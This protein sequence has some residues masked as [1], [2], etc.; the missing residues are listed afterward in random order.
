MKRRDVLKIGAGALS[1]PTASLAQ[2][3]SNARSLLLPPQEGNPLWPLAQAVLP[4][5]IGDDGQSEALGAFVAWLR[6]HREGQYLEHGYGKTR[7]A[8]TQ[9]APLEKYFRELQEL[10]TA[11]ID[12]HG[13]TFAALDNPSRRALVA[14]ALE[15]AKVTNLGSRPSGS[16]IATDL[17]THYFGSVE[18]Q[19]LAYE[20]RIGRDTCRDL[21]TSGQRP[22]R[23]TAG[24]TRR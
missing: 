11:A 2:S 17:M 19:D 8:T 12:R 22:E 15:N 21:A 18:A 14:A 3:R 5:Q 23:L 10:E 7:V 6:D 16:H 9:R 4:A 20:A 1:L 24:S 13:K